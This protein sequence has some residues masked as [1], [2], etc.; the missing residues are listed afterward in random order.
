MQ[1]EIWVVAVKRKDGNLPDPNKVLG[2]C[3]PNKT[4]AS[5]YGECVFFV[6]EP[7]ARLFYSAI[8]DE[9]RKYFSVYKAFIEIV[10]PAP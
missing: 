1:T 6:N 2:M 8:D 5:K 10:S 9:M 4:E 3:N 7:D